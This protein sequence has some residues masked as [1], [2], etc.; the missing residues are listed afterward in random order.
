MFLQITRTSLL[1]NLQ[2][3]KFSGYPLI[4]SCFSQNYSTLLFYLI[5]T[6]SYLFNDDEGLKLRFTERMPFFNDFSVR[7][8]LLAGGLSL[9]ALS[10]KPPLLS[11][12]RR[13]LLSVGS[14]VGATAPPSS[15]LLRDVKE[16]LTCFEGL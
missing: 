4:S 11:P 2:S 16:A 3:L 14:G 1:P 15:A 12:T 13:S 7:L 9:L 6:Y 5:L 8:F 10:T